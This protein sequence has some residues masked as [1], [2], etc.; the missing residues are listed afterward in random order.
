V[1]ARWTAQQVLALAP[2][3]RS[4]R[5]ARALGDLRRW[6]DLG[7]TGSL[8]Y[9]RC[10]GSGRQPYQVTVDLT[11][12]AFKCTC[13]S[14]KLPCKH[15][16]ALLLLW[17]EHGDAVGERAAAADFADEWAAER[18]GRAD[19]RTARAEVDPE[20]RARRQAEREATMTAGLDEL[21]RWLGDLVRQGLAG[22]RRQPYGFWDAMA[23]RLVDAQAPALAERVRHVGGSLAARDDWAETLLF[24]AGRWQLAV[25]GWRR[26]DSLDAATYAD[27]RAFLGWPH[28]PDEVEAFE[29][30]EDRWVVAGVREGTDGRIANQRTWL[31]GE[32]TGRWVVL[33][34]FAAAGA[35]LRVADVVGS[36]V[37]DAVVVHPGS[38]PNRAAWSGAQRVVAGGALPAA[39][40]VDAAVDQVAAWLA[41]DPWRDRLPVSLAG[42]VLVED[43][44]RWWL[45]DAAGDRLPLGAGVEPWAALALSGGHP[46]AVF[47]EWDAGAL[48]PAAVAPA[49]D[50]VPL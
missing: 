46:M 32:R 43:G 23:A 31:W 22:A 29:R 50:P 41:A 40:A 14:R 49:G 34:D 15:G 11:E 9:G 38:P 5:A 42:V 16:L 13:P 48:H 3:D 47:A 25:E 36:V 17:A 44:G 28:R 7:S 35:A 18:A 45:V 24:E 33:L 26:R 10:Q 37:E 4:A 21:E 19:R 12:P 1:G 2:D 30:V 20:A 6:S 39:A 8:V 27:L